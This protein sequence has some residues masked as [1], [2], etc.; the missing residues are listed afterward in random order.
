MKWLISLLG[1][2]FCSA[3][4]AAEIPTAS[5]K[6]SGFD[7]FIS[8][9]DHQLFD[10]DKPFR[11]AGMHAPELHRIENDAKGKCPQDPRGWGQ[12]F[13]WP[14]A[15]EQE[16]WIQTLTKTGHK[17]MRIY[18]LSI[19]DPSD[20]VCQR[21]TH[22]LAPDKPGGKPRLNEN[23]MLVYDRM[24]ALADKYQLRLILPFIDHWEWWGGRKQLAAFYAEQE[25]DFYDV[26]SQ[27]YAAYLDII[28]QVI[29]R[30]NTLTGRF[31]H[32]EKAIMAWETGNELKDT[33]Q[34][35]LEKT[36]AHIKALAP[37]QLVVDGTYLQLNDYAIDNPNVDIISNHFYTVNGNNKPA[38]IQQDLAQIA[39]RKAYMVGEFGLADASLL[40]EIMQTAVHY[41]HAV[42]QAVGAFIWGFRGH[43]H[44]GGFYF[45]HEGTGHSSYHLPGF[46]EADSNQELA[47]VNVV[48]TA[49][50]QMS[51]EP[52]NKLVAKPLPKP[53]PPKV[54]AIT[55]LD[56]I[57]W[58]GSP[59]GQ[60][61]RIERAKSQQGSWQIIGDNV[62]DGK[63]QFDPVND[64]L[65]ADND[66]LKPAHT[67][68]YRV[69]AKNESGESLPSNIQSFQVVK[70]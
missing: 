66:V 8:R 31:Y 38:T 6:I 30:K 26:N 55:S 53:E 59:V 32:D 25:D 4:L 49:M 29:Q 67:Y 60:R 24:I 22:I 35:F 44:N 16:N 39:G 61:Y 46:K 65:F 50:A 3:A 21:E 13:Q 28:A 63:P 45:H 54:R 18:V 40:N 1:I 56:D 43:R 70:R 47:V 14:T 58:M 27:T 68:F 33:N 48:R 52:G 5:T 10:G 2:G 36:A 37:L 17:A 12:Y 20:S 23:A 57:R 51:G 42:A 15:D 19:A 9:Q 64:R 41:Q 69:V 62:S 7:H 11:F 34:G